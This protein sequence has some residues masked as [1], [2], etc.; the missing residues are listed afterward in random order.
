MSCGSGRV[1]GT[2]AGGGTPPATGATTSQVAAALGPASCAAAGLVYPGG[3]G[4][5]L[6]SASLPR[7]VM[8][9]R[10]LYVCSLFVKGPSSG[11]ERDLFCSKT[12]WR[13]AVLV[14]LSRAKRWGTPHCPLTWYHQ[15]VIVIH[16]VICDFRPPSV[17]E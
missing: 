14:F 16:S 7:Y 1:L 10:L 8:N 9:A 17:T 3:L 12:S 13:L 5:T 15:H 11:S 2:M 6:P 4:V